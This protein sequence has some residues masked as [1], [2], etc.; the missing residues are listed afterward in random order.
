MAEN[1][2]PLTDEDMER[3]AGKWVLIRDG[4]VVA[5]SSDI[6]QVL[7]A[8][9]ARWDSVMRVPEQREVFY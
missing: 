9:N 6:E 4:R 8:R 5:A 3:Y 1:G 2:P 7:A